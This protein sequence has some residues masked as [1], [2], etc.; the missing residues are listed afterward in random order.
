MSTES[1]VNSCRTHAV[2]I[3]LESRVCELE[4]NICDI[5]THVRSRQVNDLFRTHDHYPIRFIYQPSP[6]PFIIAPTFHLQ[7]P[8]AA[9]PNPATAS[10][11]TPRAPF[12]TPLDWLDE[13]APMWPP[14][15]QGCILIPHE[16]M[17]P[18]VTFR[19][20]GGFLLYASRALDGWWARW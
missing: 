17:S 10:P 18:V 9:S 6:Y 3:Y 13:H 15:T 7:P 12:Q 8:S 2:G 5:K 20:E 19:D 1:S 11:Q 4:V 14:P 16:S